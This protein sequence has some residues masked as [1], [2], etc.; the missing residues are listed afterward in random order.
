MPD[1]ANHVPHMRI[2]WDEARISLTPEQAAKLLRSSK[3]SIA[4]S[5]GEGQL[6]LSMNSFMLQPSEEKIVAAQLSQLMREH[7]S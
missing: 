5:S 2:T 3:P 4:I 6:G 7:A 1:I